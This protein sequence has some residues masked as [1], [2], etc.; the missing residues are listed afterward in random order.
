MPF[1]LS[2]DELLSTTRSVRKRLD[3]DRP[4]EPEIIRECLELALQAPS[5]GN[6]QGW[7][8]IVVTDPEK[9]RA[10][11]QLYKQAWDIYR[12]WSLPDPDAPKEADAPPEPGDLAA[13]KRMISSAAY[14]AEHLHEVP[15]LLI[16]C[17]EGRVEN[18]TPMPAFQQASAYGSVL[19]AVWSF[20]LAARARG[21]G[22]CWTTLHLMFEEQAA[23]VLG[24]PYESITQTA[25]IPVAYTK[26]D[27][28][29]PGGR[30]S[31]DG[32]LHLEGW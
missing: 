28:F 22:T 23:Q 7:H 27:Q 31:L 2:P 4:V 8:F 18:A 30:K 10:L 13:V 14:L 21:L 32:V 24:V 26:G 5:G 15:V 16:A 19:P 25:L 29:Q 12:K 9:R 11:G 3:F 17:M 20:M 1:N 6:R